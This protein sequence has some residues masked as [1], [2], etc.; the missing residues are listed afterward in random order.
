MERYILAHDLGTSG[1]KATLFSESGKLIA[2]VT[3]AYEAHMFNG[4]WAEQDPEAWWQAVKEGTREIT[5]QVDPAQIA[6]ISFGAQS[7]GCLPVDRQGNAL[8]PSIIHC[9][10]R[11]TRQ[12][13][14]L[15]QNISADE[16]YRIT[17]NPISPIYALEKIMWICDNEPDVY[18]NTYKFINAKDYIVAKLTGVIVTDATDTLG[19]GVLDLDTLCYSEEVFAAAGVALDKMPD[20][21]PSTFVAGEITAAMSRETGLAVGTPVVIGAADGCAASIGA[22]CVCDN[23]TYLY[24]GSSAWI[25]RTVEKRP[26]DEKR[27]ITTSLSPVPGL[28]FGYGTMQAAGTANQWLRDT[29]AQVEKDAAAVQGVSPYKLIDELAAT[30]PPGANGVL[31]HPYLLGERCP[32]WNSEAK[33]A[34]LGI[35]ANTT[36]ADLLRAVLEGVAYNLRCIYDIVGGPQQIKEM[37]FIGGG[38]AS[39]LWSGILADVLGCTLQ[40]PHY[41]DEA[42][43]MGAALIGA[44]GC[45]LFKDFSKV[46]SFIRTEKEYHPNPAYKAVYDDAFRRF[47]STYAALEPEYGTWKGEASC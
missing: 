16:Y 14:Q 2:S 17:G 1:D 44:V 33:A 41:I 8:R 26:Q 6:A 5:A 15:A 4:N 13:K 11:A 30:S 28:Y 3:K 31:F 9:D 7:M 37:V 24:I 10:N 45:G 42:T 32:R 46:S 38:A 43:S 39:P 22:G 35:T 40:V 36:R 29:I 20:I 23:T 27:D 18:K 34:F 47:N 25:S 12:A 19:S 21:M